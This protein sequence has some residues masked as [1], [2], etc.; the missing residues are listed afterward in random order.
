MADAPAPEAPKPP[1]L[2]HAQKVAEAKRK[3]AE[4]MAKAKAKREAKA[5]E[6]EAA[7]AGAVE[8]P[9]ANE[10]FLAGEHNLILIDW[11]DTL[12]PTSVWKNR[13]APDAAQPL[14]ASKVAALS[15][16]ISEFIKTLQ[17]FGDVKIVTHGCKGW[18]E[19]SSAVLLPETRALLG[20]LP[21]RYRDSFGQKYMVK[22]PSGLKCAPA[23]TTW[24]RPPPPPRLGRPPPRGA[25]PQVH[26]R[27]RLRGRQLR[28]VVQDRHVLPVHLREEDG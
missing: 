13:I 24:P 3:G 23:R 20:S 28:R 21:A 18:F 6:K 14:R 10:L 25:R 1:P 12:F 17:K 7:G 11:D 8:A 22:K 15:E 16:A 2:T 5:A 26:D 19:K 27:D 4:M 9:S